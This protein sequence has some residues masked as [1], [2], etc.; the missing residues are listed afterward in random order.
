MRSGCLP[1]ALSK[2]RVDAFAPVQNRTTKEDERACFGTNGQVFVI[3]ITLMGCVSG[4]VTSIE[5][6][7]CGHRDQ[8]GRRLYCPVETSAC[9]AA[10]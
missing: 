3:E 10:A 9:V 1:K 6:V 7:D 2:L 5:V 8:G 4:F